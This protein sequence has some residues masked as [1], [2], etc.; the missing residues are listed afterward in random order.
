MLGRQAGL[1]T[2]RSTLSS[3]HWLIYET[4]QQEL[5]TKSQE[6]NV[7]HGVC[8]VFVNNNLADPDL[9]PVIRC[10]NNESLNK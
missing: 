1:K 5:F 7:I 4:D 2:D 10:T 3:V 9:F 6:C 8:E